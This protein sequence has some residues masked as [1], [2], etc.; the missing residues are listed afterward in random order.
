MYALTEMVGDKYKT[1][2][3][4]N[5]NGDCNPIEI[6]I[7]AKLEKNKLTDNAIQEIRDV[8][9]NSF[10]GG[11]KTVDKHS[12][13]V[14]SVDVKYKIEADFLKIKNEVYLAFNALLSAETEL[15]DGIRF[16]FT[17]HLSPYI[18]SC[19]ADI[20]PDILNEISISE[21]DNGTICVSNHSI[22]IS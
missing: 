15:Q 6:G 14:Q 16:D 11:I 21:K 7:V 17:R 20:I 19:I 5:Y 12:S 2:L 22:L 18:K 9:L 10:F 8:F 13:D 4:D 3:C 1:E